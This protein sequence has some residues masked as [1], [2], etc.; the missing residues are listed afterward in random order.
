[1]RYTQYIAAPCLI[2]LLWVAP[3]QAAEK[4]KPKF[5]PGP[6]SSFA[7][8][9]TIDQVTVGARPFVSEADL[10]A[11]FGKLNPNDHGVLP[12]LVVIAND[13]DQ[14]LSLEFL[15]V[16]LMTPDR[17]RLEAT[18]AADLKYLSGPPKPDMTPGPI[19][20]RTPR[21]SRR[22]SPLS[23]WEI[24][25]RAFSARMLP[26]R[27]T[28]S[29]FFYFQTRFRGGSTL[30]LTGIRQAQ[31]G[32]ELFYFELPLE[33][34]QVSRSAGRRVAYRNMPIPNPI[35]LTK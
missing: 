8:R 29:G 12:I 14:T 18:P 35:P 21:L 5:S 34:Q 2:V 17:R 16:E 1:M 27:E 30:F 28:A 31:S 9:Q 11:A 23:A 10:R 19:P 33:S 26:A 6:I 20:G 15:R 24:E 7:A 4:E 3:A 13:S 22:K 25:G 32:K